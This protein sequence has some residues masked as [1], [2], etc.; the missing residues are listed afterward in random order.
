M[1]VKSA[2]QVYKL[3]IVEAVRNSNDEDLLELIWKLLL[4][5]QADE[6]SETVRG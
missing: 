6:G 3:Q 2:L 5:E 4:A 1:D